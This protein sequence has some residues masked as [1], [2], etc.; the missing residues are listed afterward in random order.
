MSKNNLQKKQWGVGT[1]RVFIM[2]KHLFFKGK[3][4]FITSSDYKRTGDHFDGIV[5]HRHLFSNI[6]TNYNLSDAERSKTAKNN[7]I[8]SLQAK[9]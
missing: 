7:N 2:E 8:Q 5:Q 3:M 1:K 4:D 6:F 9:K